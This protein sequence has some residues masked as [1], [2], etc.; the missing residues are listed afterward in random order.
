MRGTNSCSGI[1]SAKPPVSAS[2]SCAALRP[3]CGAAFSIEVRNE[4]KLVIVYELGGRAAKPTEADFRTIV[5]N[6]A[7]RHGLQIDSIGLVKSGTVP[8]TTSGKIRRQECRS[9]FLAGT[10]ATL[11]QWHVGTAELSSAAA[12]DLADAVRFDPSLGATQVL[13]IVIGEVATVLGAAPAS[14]DPRESIYALGLDSL[15]AARLRS[16]LLSIFGV[17][18]DVSDFLAVSTLADLADQI[19]DR[20]SAGSPVIPERRA[21]LLLE[22]VAQLSEKEAKETLAAEVQQLPRPIG[23]R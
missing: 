6:V 17:E 5:R 12:A 21:K 9:R 23:S 11:H 20:V 10:L 3:G 1:E 19:A 22:Q 7:Q 8:K 2:G 13:A 18:L 16:R 4:E 15:V 14:I